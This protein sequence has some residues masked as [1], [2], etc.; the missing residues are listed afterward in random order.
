[1]QNTNKSLH[2][3]VNS[4][5]ETLEFFLQVRELL[6]INITF[7]SNPSRMAIFHHS[8]SVIIGYTCM[9]YVLPD[10]ESFVPLGR[11]KKRNLKRCPLR[12]APDTS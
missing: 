8:N 2:T 5:G 11:P 12:D 4:S 9:W 3:E 7:M 6:K 1:M 10:C